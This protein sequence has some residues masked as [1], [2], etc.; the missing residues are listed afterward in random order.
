MAPESSPPRQRIVD[1]LAGQN[2]LI[3]GSTGFL[4]KV[5]LEKL[6][7]GVETIQ[8]CYLLVRSRTGGLSAAERVR[9]TVIRSRAFDRLRAS[10]GDGFEA[11]CEEKIHVVEGDLTQVRFGLSPQAYDELAGKITLVVNSA[12]TVTFDEQLDLAIQLNTRGPTRLLQFA[13]DCG[14]VPFMHVSTC[15]VC[16]ARR[17]DI[18]EDCS[19]PEP[20]RESLPRDA[21]TGGFDLD[22]IVQSCLDESAKIRRSN[23]ESTEAARRAL[24]DAGM[25]RARSYGW[26]DTYTFTKWLGEQLLIRDH[27]DVPVVI[28]RPAIIEG[29]YDEPA[30]GWI[31]GLRMADPIIVAY[32]KGKLSEFPG[33][34]DVAIDLIP[35][36][37]VANAMIAALPDKAAPTDRVPILQ[38]ASSGRNP[39][40]VGRLMAPLQRAFRK[41]PMYDDEGRPIEVGPLKLVDKD[42]FIE[43]WR[44]RQSRLRRLQSLYKK[45]GLKGK[46]FRRLSVASR[47]I[48]QLIY[49]ATIY[50]PYTHLDCRFSDDALRAVEA[51]MHPDDRKRFPFDVSV[52]DWADYIINRHVPGLRSFVLGTGLA[53][54]GRIRGA[55]EHL[56][57]DAAPGPE[58]LLTAETLFEVFERSAQRFKDKAALQ[59]KRGPR[60]IRYSFEEALGAS[61]AVMQRMIDRGCGPGDRIAICAESCPEWGIAYMA[62]MRAGMT[63]V[64]LDPQ[65]PAEEAWSACRFVGA[66][67][68]CASPGRQR[69]LEQ[70]RGPDDAPLVILREPFIPP[71]GASRDITCKPV[72]VDGTQP[73]SILFT[74]GTTVAPK[75]VPLTHHNLIANARALHQVHRLYS[76]D[77]LLSV[78]PMYHAFEFTGGFLC[79]IVA[80]ATITYVADL[81]GNEIRAAAQTTGTTVMLVVPRLLQSFHDAIENQASKSGLLARGYLRLAGALSDRSGRRLA[82]PLFRP[83]HKRFGGR[84]RMFVSGGSALE[85]SIFDAFARMGFAVYEGYGLTETSP[86]LAVNPPQASRRGSVGKVLPNVT[87]EIRNQNLEGIGELWVKGPSVMSGYLDNPEATRDVLVNG[88]FNTGDLGKQDADGYLTITGRSKDLIVTG[89]G[90]NVYPDEVEWRYRD[91]PFM[92][93]ICVFG[94]A[95][96]DGV[97]DVVHAVIVLDPVAVAEHDPSSVQ[98]EIR[99]AAEAISEGL[100]PHQRIGALHFWDRELPKTSTMKAKR[101]LVRDLIVEAQMPAKSPGATAAGS[102]GT[103]L[104]NA[105]FAAHEEV[106][107]PVVRK[108]LARQTKHP[109]KEIGRDAHLLLDLGVDSIGK[110]EVIGE[111]EAQFGLDIDDATAGKIARVS[112]LLAVIG[113]RKPIPGGKRDPSQWRK[114]LASESAAQRPTNGHLPAPLVPVR[115]AVRGSVGLFMKT[116]VRVRAV[117]REHIPDS[118]AF[119]LAPNHCSHLDSPAVLQAV[120]GKRRVWVAGAQDYFFNTAVKRLLFGKILDTIAFDRQSDGVQ[121]LRRCG[122][123]LRRGDGLLI[124]PEGTRSVSGELQPFKV[125]VSVLA[126][127]HGAPIIPVRIDRTYELLPKGRRLVHPGV[128]TVTFGQPVHPP[129]ASQTEDHYQAFQTVTAQVEASVQA[130]VR[131]GRA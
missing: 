18:V 4:A 115:W 99:A 30:P 26:N 104:P 127:E 87:L 49:F 120:S 94:M 7:R 5:F 102:A 31:D 68:I 121:G 33:L 39:C 82:K 124:F 129:P 117:G 13:K 43:R 78:L 116:Y 42:V 12:A 109:A 51:R 88:W 52:I 57:R 27:G 15:Y 48:E 97:G 77:E 37:F 40:L 34:L 74:S 79:P 32:G 90:K 53:P 55:V 111:I 91:L 28:F 61:G 86:V 14:D 63:A 66:R 72:E 50:S 3:T 22:A 20:A 41:H 29:S 16:G 101:G 35:V 59:I 106:T 113:D 125:G 85:P 100:P 11:L 25:R 36:D 46:R 60:W 126:M 8:G 89:A 70:A 67:L 73:A 122:D 93:E 128:V 56:D 98:R 96:V 103:P 131:G 62:I 95:S 38:C 71:P 84:L 19:A 10:L 118:G 75:A 112:D 44:R 107:L 123:A 119:I 76:S 105:A 81:K 65:L 17:G 108:I 114:R 54:D 92:K 6:L 58:D 1:R 130:M 9:R 2:L 24:I 69:S 80:G 64:P 110:I 23:G 47:Q 45:I 21:E 83:V